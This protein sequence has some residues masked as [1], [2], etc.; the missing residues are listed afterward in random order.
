[1]N[2]ISWKKNLLGIVFFFG[3]HN[4]FYLSLWAFDVFIITIKLKSNITKKKEKIKTQNRASV[5]LLVLY[6]TH[7]L[8]AFNKMTYIYVSRRAVVAEL[9]FHDNSE[10]NQSKLLQQSLALCYSFTCNVLTSTTFPRLSTSI[11]VTPSLDQ[12]TQLHQNIIVAHLCHYNPFVFLMECGQKLIKKEHFIE[13]MMY[14]WL[15]NLS[16]CEC[17][18]RRK[19]L[20]APNLVFGAVEL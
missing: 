14:L 8:N 19:T 16:R 4:W 9:F 3:L 2:P 1:M 5:Y 6:R 10:W 11:T 17:F 13:S 18:S 15:S 20:A 7:N 12:Y